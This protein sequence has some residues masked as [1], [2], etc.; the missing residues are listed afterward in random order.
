MAFHTRF[1]EYLHDNGFLTKIKLIKL[2][3]VDKLF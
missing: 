2:K 3:Q 1:K